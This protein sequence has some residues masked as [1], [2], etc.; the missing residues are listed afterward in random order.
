MDEELTQGGEQKSNTK[1]M[2]AAA[3]A[4][5]VVILGLAL[6][7]FLGSDSPAA[8]TM[9]SN[10]FGST[11]SGDDVRPA[12][13]RPGVGDPGNFENEPT[14]KPYF[15]QLSKI[16]TAGSYFY[17]T[18]DGL[19]MARYVAKENGHVYDINIDTGEERKISNTT[20]PRV[21]EALFGDN[22]NVIVV[23][24]LETDPYTKHDV[25]KTFFGRLNLPKDTSDP[26][27]VGSLTGNYFK[28]GVSAI[29][30][31]PNGKRLFYLLPK[32][33]G[34]TIG[35]TVDIA[36]GEPREV[37][38]HQFS[39]WLPQ[40]LNTGKIIMTTKPS[41]RIPGFSYLYDPAT[42][43]LKRLVREKNGLVTLSD[44]TAKHMLFSENVA[45]NAVL[46]VHG[47]LIGD[48]G[49]VLNNVPLALTTLAE[50]CA[51]TKNDEKVVCAVYSAI[52]RKELPDDWYKGSFFFEDNFWSVDMAT[53]EPNLLA[54]PSLM[55]YGPFDATSLSVSEDES[56]ILF[57][58]KRDETLWMLGMPHQIDQTIEAA[59][60]EELRDI[61]G[62]GVTGKLSTT[63]PKK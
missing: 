11:G 28:D 42:G 7:L 57:I 56:A 61:E 62:S 40:I 18:A 38:R 19:R 36:S 23:R 51:W 32:Q 43:D 6:Y 30:I 37:F 21:H 22:G 27:T 55:Q 39:E 48:E 49:V 52:P 17:T 58:N 46:S 34:Y 13:E 44:S 24:S 2:I 5:L 8:V 25:I 41:S 20:I 14:D 45:A 9:R 29:T 3:A 47:E 1:L 26:S 54:D 15:R 12:P 50:K 59:S 10:F 63:T 16:P 31:S 33:D 60:E 53:R 4:L 35:N